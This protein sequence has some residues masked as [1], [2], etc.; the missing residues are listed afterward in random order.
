MD[1]RPNKS[2]QYISDIVIFVG[3]VLLF[4]TISISNTQEGMYGQIIGYGFLA[5]GFIIKAATSSN[6]FSCI[7]ASKKFSYFL[8]SIL[9][10]IIVALLAFLIIAMLV[11]YYNRIVGGKVTSDFYMFSKMF[12]VLVCVQI[13]IYYYGTNKKDNPNPGILSSAYGMSIYLLSLLNVL[14][15]I[16]LYVILAYYTTDG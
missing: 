6:L 8:Y 12:I 4:M 13:G 5:V 16:S 14:V 1:C 7:E 9:P 11:N 2:F 10:F 3:I 15:L